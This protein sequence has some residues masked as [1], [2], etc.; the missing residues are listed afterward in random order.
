MQWKLDY[1]KHAY[2]FFSYLHTRKID[3]IESWSSY[4]AL[5]LWLSYKDRKN[6]TFWKGS[7]LLTGMI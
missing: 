6:V 4:S 7:R 1:Y 5:D 3:I 2:N